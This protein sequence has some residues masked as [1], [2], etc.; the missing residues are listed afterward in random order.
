MLDIQPPILSTSDFRHLVLYALN[1]LATN[2]TGAKK[3]IDL[4]DAPSSYTG[5][6]GY[7]IA[8]KADESGLEFS[9]GS[10]GAPSGPAG[11]DLAGTYPNPTIASGIIPTALPPNGPAGGS[12][13]G[14][15]PN[16]TIAPGVIPT[17]LP[18]S[19]S[20]G[21]DL[22][23]TYPNP[24][25]KAS[26]DLTGSPTATTATADDNTTRIATTAFIAG[27]ASSANPIMD[28]A[29]AAGTSLKYSRQDHV[30]PTDTSRAPLASPA[31]TGT[32]TAP[33]AALGTNTTQLAT[34]EFV[35]AAIT[36]GGGNADNLIAT[37]VNADSVALARGT[38]VYA[39][40][41]TGNK[42][43]V[44]RADNTTDATSATTL[45]FI[46]DTSLAAGAQGTITLYGSMDQLNLG[47][48]FND[49]DPIYLGTNGG[50]QKTKPVAPAHGV[51]LGV[52]ERA[53]AGNGIA[54]VK[55][56][57]G[58]ELDELHDV[59]ITGA[60]AGQILRL[61]TDGLWKNVTPVADLVNAPATI[62]GHHATT[63]TPALGGQTYYFGYPHDVGAV[64]SA[65]DRGFK[66]PYAGVVVAAAG[67]ISVGGTLAVTPS[68][69][70]EF[71]LFNKTTSTSTQL[72]SVAN[73]SWG[74]SLT[75]VRASGLAISVNTTDE[76][77]MR[78][79]TPSFSTA[80]TSCR[81]YLNIFFQRT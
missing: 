29:A 64:T 34:T 20:A 42:L 63:L 27:Q 57:N 80:P 72:I 13:A 6:A 33:T 31:F 71:A 25:I 73:T 14:S 37:V 78:L 5:F 16:P 18:P 7:T 47:S 28:G 39:F 11:G 81:H 36:T 79:T 32:P 60:V 45:G 15:Y 52:V 59:L 62:G 3:F 43:S 2:G 50:Y 53:N 66:F 55:V 10:G 19:G 41:S 74:A 58:Y 68:G 65:T 61:D 23:G 76:Y 46:N 4:E 8:V 49:G 1:Y 56:Q 54:Y 12:L 38:V 67:T 24:T 21:G 30:H 77:A 44:K 40:G 35:Q 9:L 75:T 48:P 51:F 70:A 22:T 17:S 69:T 26:V